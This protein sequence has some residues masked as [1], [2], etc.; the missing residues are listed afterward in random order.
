MDGQLGQVAMPTADH[1]GRLSLSPSRTVRRKVFQNRALWRAS[2]GTIYCRRAE[3]RQNARTAPDSRV[4]ANESDHFHDRLPALAGQG[5][6]PSWGRNVHLAHDLSTSGL[7]VVL[8]MPVPYTSSQVPNPSP[9]LR[10]HGVRARTAYADP[11]RQ[12]AELHHVGDEGHRAC[13]C[14]SAR[15]T[16]H[17]HE[18]A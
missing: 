7:T 1:W 8:S 4:V 15:A 16:H 17:G 10:E 2:R 11:R 3:N 18:V 12:F 6:V 13:C 5:L 14:G 9:V